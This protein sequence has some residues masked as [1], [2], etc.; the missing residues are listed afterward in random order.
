MPSSM[1]SALALS[2]QSK[3]PHARNCYVCFC[4]SGTW[5]GCYAGG[6]NWGGVAVDEERQR[7]IANTQDLP[8]VVQLIER[9]QAEKLEQDDGAE[10]A[11]MRGTPYWLRRELLM[12]PFGVP[13]NAPPWGQLAAVRRGK[14]AEDVTEEVRSDHDVEVFRA[15]HEVQSRCV[16]QQRFGLDVGVVFGHVSKGV[17]PQH[18]AVSLGV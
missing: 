9:E 15:L 16:N 11:P 17:I 8:M 12:S 7:L 13:C 5:A 1:A 6:S 10:Y 18:H 2:I 14:V 4:S 3:I